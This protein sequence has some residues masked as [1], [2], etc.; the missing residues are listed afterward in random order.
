LAE[1]LIAR[2]QS[3]LDERKFDVALQ[4][5]ETARSIDANDRRLSALDDRIASL[6]AELGPAQINAALNAQN[7][8]RASQLIEDAARAKALPPAKLAQLRDDVR[9]R[10]DEFDSARLLKLAETRLQQDKLVEPRGDSAAF[11]LEQAKQAGEPP[12]TLQ[13]LYRNSSG[14]SPPPCVAPSMP[15]TS[16]MRSIGWRNC[17]IWGAGHRHRRTAERSDGGARRARARQT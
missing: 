12:A 1:I 2:V 8:D 4:S 3:A 7:F 16:A 10:R 5:L 9:K 13:P 15:S 11:Y 14:K 17:A 6:R